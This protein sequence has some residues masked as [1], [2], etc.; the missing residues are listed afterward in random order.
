MFVIE[1]EYLCDKQH[2][3]SRFSFR[4]IIIS[5]LLWVNFLSN[6]CFPDIEINHWIFTWICSLLGIAV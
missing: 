6:F 5:Y 2:I 4:Y 3:F 1:F